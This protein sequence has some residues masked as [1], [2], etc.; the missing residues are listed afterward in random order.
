M[1]NSELGSKHLCTECGARFY[2]LGRQPP[3]CPKCDTVVA[4]ATKPR[5]S[6]SRS[7]KPAMR[8]VPVEKGAVD[9]DTSKADK[10]DDEEG[11]KLTE[12]ASDD[13]KNNNI[14]EEV[15]KSERDS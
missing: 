1:A 6:R 4:A 12:E 13:D 15:D 3:T 8:P 14:L 9:I 5:P 11:D 7:T 2:D 10:G